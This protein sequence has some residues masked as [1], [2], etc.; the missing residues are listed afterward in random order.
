MHRALENLSSDAFALRYSFISNPI[1]VY[2]ALQRSVDVENV[3]RALQS[4][5]I[6]E[7]TLRGFCASV[8]TDLE[9]GKRL[10]QELAL[11]AI[12]VALESRA[13]AFAEEY[14]L[15]LARLDRAEF[16][17][18]IR[19]AR[20]VSR[21]RMALPANRTKD[22]T[23]GEETLVSPAGDWCPAPTPREVAV[24]QSEQHFELEMS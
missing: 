12:A 15:D 20:Q 6:T 14:V 4:G 2:R 1:A 22:F 16:P 7:D 11:A 8:L 9:P 19:V 17:T 23:L 24:G 21:E 18:A 13:T 3:R 5:E 10:P